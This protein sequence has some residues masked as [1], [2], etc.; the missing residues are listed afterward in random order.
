MMLVIRGIIILHLVG[1]CIAANTTKN[2]SLNTGNKLAV[3]GFE[4][5]GIS[6]PLTEHITEELRRSI[7][8]LKIF[9]VQNSDLTN[10]VN[11]FLPTGKDYW[12][13]WSEECAVAIGKQL[14]VNYVV[15]G[16]IEKEEG[17]YNINGRLFSVDM[18]TL[19]NEFSMNSSGITDSLLLEMKKMAYNV[20]GL[21]IPDT[22]SVGSDTSQVDI[23]QDIDRK[24]LLNFPQLPQMPTKIKA[25]MMSTVI[26]GSGQIW[27]DKMYPGY[28]FMGTEASLGLL[29][30]IAYY[31]YNKAWGD[32]D[33]NYSKYQNETDPHNLYELRPLIKKHA[34]DTKTYNSFMKNIRGIAGSI[35]LVNMVHA[36][37]VAPEDDYF[38]GESFFD[39]E[40]R[41]DINQI[42]FILN[43]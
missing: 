15:A 29:T 2:I 6:E 18:E 16:N 34:E 27:V 7:K 22:L 19:V 10:D 28:G 40:Y 11:V 24:R 1:F 5:I 12:A 4:G 42:Q 20:S 38:D 39:I 35:W 21:P 43:F 30:L 31:Q 26:P 13:C 8:D 33:K 14:K 9:R 17:I 41:P 32:F 36:Y 3:L 25:L 23:T 37:M